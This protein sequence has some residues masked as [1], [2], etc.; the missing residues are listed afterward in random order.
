MSDE[1]INKM[2]AMFKGKAEKIAETAGQSLGEVAFKAKK[3]IDATA[4]IAQS[5]KSALAELG[6]T[7][8]SARV[9]FE[10]AM[11]EAEERARERA[12]RESADKAKAEPSAGKSG[13]ADKPKETGP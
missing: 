5:A 6:Q 2:K 11:V 10:Q 4:P 12:D 7:L 8:S 1:T 13:S 3:F 9:S